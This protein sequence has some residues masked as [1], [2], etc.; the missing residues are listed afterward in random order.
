MKG[1]SLRG[2]Y[3]CLKIKNKYVVC[4]INE[5]GGTRSPTLMAMTVRVLKLAEL[6]NVFLC[7]ARQGRTKCSSRQAFALS[8]NSQDRVGASRHS[9]C[10]GVQSEFVGH[11]HD[12][13]VCEQTEHA[14]TSLHL[15]VP[16]RSL[17]VDV[18]VCP[19][20]NEIC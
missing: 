7:S 9:F 3:I 12:R 17:L 10:L 4:N 13:F 11:A 8:C 18:L 19:W 15:T 2:R 20:P 14:T 5:Q 16:G 1:A 6:H